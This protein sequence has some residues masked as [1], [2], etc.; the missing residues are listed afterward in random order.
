MQEQLYY[1]LIRQINTEDGGYIY[2]G[3]PVSSII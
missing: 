3:L 1:S 2:K